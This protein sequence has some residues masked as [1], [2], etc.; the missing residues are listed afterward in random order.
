[1]RRNLQWVPWQLRSRSRVQ[2]RAE[3]YY[4]YI[5]RP[6]HVFHH[7][8]QMASIENNRKLPACLTSLHYSRHQWRK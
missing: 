6:F 1:M 7:S 3:L 2:G 4:N 5:L 8:K